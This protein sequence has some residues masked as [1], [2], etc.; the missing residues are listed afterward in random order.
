MKTISALSFI[1]TNFTTTSCHLRLGFT[2]TS[3]LVFLRISLKVS[4]GGSEASCGI[5]NLSTLI[6]I[7]RF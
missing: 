5:C 3:S 1:Q 6:Y 7:H 4:E 2:N